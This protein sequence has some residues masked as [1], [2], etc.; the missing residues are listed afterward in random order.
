MGDGGVLVLSAVKGGEG[1]GPDVK[2]GGHEGSLAVFGGKGR[3]RECEFDLADA[4]M[5]R[6]LLRQDHA[7]VK[8]YAGAVVLPA[9]DWGR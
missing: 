1:R 2:A 7:A 6:V 5:L 3:R 9:F 8:G 4:F